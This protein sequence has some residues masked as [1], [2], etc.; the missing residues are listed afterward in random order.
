MSKSDVIMLTILLHCSPGTD[1]LL[2][3]QQKTA[4]LQDA[5][6][7]SSITSLALPSLRVL[8]ICLEP[9]RS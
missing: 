6:S 5:S 2:L 1:M 3:P 9:S 7:S 4:Q 8:A